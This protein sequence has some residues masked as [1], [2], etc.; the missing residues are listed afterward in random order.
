MKAGCRLTAAAGLPAAT[1]SHN[2]NALGS[3]KHVWLAH[4]T[5]G[6]YQT[7]FDI[8]NACLVRSRHLLYPK[9]AVQRFVIV[10]VYC[11]I[12][13]VLLCF[14]ARLNVSFLASLSHLKIYV[15]IHTL[16]PSLKH[17]QFHKIVVKNVIKQWSWD[18]PFCQMLTTGNV[19]LIS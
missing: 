19:T 1:H 17:T 16:P 15:K 14:P 8:S 7:E 5:C 11:T 4:L 6:I 2:T 13:K 10:S 18:E 3:K 9:V 12:Q